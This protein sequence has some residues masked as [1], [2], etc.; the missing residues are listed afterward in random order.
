MEPYRG[1]KQKAWGGGSR[2]I[3]G[4]SVLRLVC[5]SPRPV[6]VANVLHKC[7]CSS[8]EVKRAEIAQ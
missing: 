4:M 7:Q 8:Q 6:E 3:P 1:F 5:E 2:K